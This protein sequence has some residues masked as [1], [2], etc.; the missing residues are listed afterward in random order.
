MIVLI[1]DEKCT[2]ISCLSFWINH[3]TKNNIPFLIYSE[4]FIE[5]I[6][7]KYITQDKFILEDKKNILLSEYEFLF[8]YTK[9]NTNE[10]I[11]SCDLTN[12]YNELNTL[13]KC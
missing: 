3:Y 9:S 11:L 10:I 12:I 8:S 2:I 13:I 1:Y 4:T 5:N 6:D 7:S